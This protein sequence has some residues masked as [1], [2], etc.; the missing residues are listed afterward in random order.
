ML[1]SD[2]GIRSYDQFVPFGFGKRMCL[3][4][5][6]ARQQVFIFMV[7]LLQSLEIKLHP[8]NQPLPN[9]DSCRM[10]FAR[11]VQPFYVSVQKR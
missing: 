11:V 9:Q 1:I 5:S 4:E 2:S 3:G 8:D 6:L 7:T 10:G